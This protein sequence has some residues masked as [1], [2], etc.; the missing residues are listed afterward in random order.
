MRRD[1]LDEL[2]RRSHPELDNLGV[3]VAEKV[4][5]MRLVCSHTS[6]VFRRDDE[7]L[8][9]PALPC[10]KCKTK[11]LKVTQSF[12]A[13]LEVNAAASIFRYR[14]VYT[15]AIDV[16]TGKVLREPFGSWI[17]APFEL[18]PK[19]GTRVPPPTFPAADR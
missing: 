19:S 8:D 10:P 7:V 13:E 5:C 15:P 4:R 3:L 11:R 12:R 18:A 14:R 9:V 1:A 16:D 6:M 17:Y 2:Q